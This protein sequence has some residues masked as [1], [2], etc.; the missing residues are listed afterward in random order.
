MTFPMSVGCT[1]NSKTVRP[2]RSTGVTF[3]ASGRSTRPLTTNSRKACIA[4]LASSDGGSGLV[5]F[6]NKAGHR[7]GRLR[8]FADPVL[9]PFAVQDE[10]VAFLQRLIGADFF[11]ELAV[12][13]AAIVRHH[14]A[15]HGVV[16]RPDSFHPYSDCH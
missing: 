10:V 11:N 5:G 15:E 16:L 14:Y 8:A 3:T 4:G 13:R 9:R 2:S 6:A 7:V 12:A 1:R